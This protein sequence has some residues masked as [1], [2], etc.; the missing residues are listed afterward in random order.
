MM[1][2]I[3]I[4]LIMALSLATCLWFLRATA[5][6]QQGSEDQQALSFYNKQLEQ[7]DA[8]QADQSLDP[9]QAE[10]ARLELS[11]GCCV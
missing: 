8:E 9:S 7:I 2:W 11:G 4:A 3:V 5:D 6:Q 10:Q 1:L